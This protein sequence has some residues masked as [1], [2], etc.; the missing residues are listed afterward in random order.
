MKLTKF[1]DIPAF[2]RDGSW[3]CDYDPQSALE[4]I[5][6]CQTRSYG[7]KLQIDP[8][9]QRGHVWTEQQQIAWL[10]FFFRGGKTGRVIYLNHPGW[11]RD[12]DGDFV[13]VDGKQRIE[14]LRRFYAN[15]IPIFGSYFR[16]FTDKSR[17][18]LINIRININTLKTRAEVLKWYIEMNAGGT[19]HTPEEIEKVRDLLK[20]EPKQ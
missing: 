3:E 13:L 18:S 1:Q 2:T 6:E 15:E 9:F 4:F 16:E 11:M 7:S 17:H 10:E 14:A 19:P 8:D 5:K 20:K 12:Y